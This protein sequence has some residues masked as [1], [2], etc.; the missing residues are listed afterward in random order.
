MHYNDLEF[1]GEIFYCLNQDKHQ[2]V[3]A[4]DITVF[5]IVW[6]EHWYEIIVEITWKGICNTFNFSVKSIVCIILDIE[7]DDFSKNRMGWYAGSSN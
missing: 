6:L 1:F 7:F 5:Y 4:Y 3:T 2:A